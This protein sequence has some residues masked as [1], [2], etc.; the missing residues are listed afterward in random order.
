[1]AHGL[2]VEILDQE[3]SGDESLAEAADHLRDNLREAAEFQVGQ[4]TEPAAAGT[5]A[6][7]A[8]MFE[9]ISIGLWSTYQISRTAAAQKLVEILASWAE[10]HG[11]QW[12]IKAG[13]VEIEG[14]NVSGKD[15]GEIARSLGPAGIDLRDAPTA[16][17]PAPE[18]PR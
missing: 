10:S 17:T 1:M 6:D 12:R 14:Q 11:K 18:K 7:G 3:S 2:I 9:L 4:V 15:I 13:A 16:T 5:R 8:A